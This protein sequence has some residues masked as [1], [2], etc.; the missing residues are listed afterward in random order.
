VVSA[1]EGQIAA[2]LIKHGPL[3][4]KYIDL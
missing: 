4:S 2:N 3:A 1:D